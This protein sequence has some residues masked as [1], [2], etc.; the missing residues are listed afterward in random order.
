MNK[1]DNTPLK[2]YRLMTHTG[3]VIRYAILTKFEVNSKNYALGINGSN[4][5]YV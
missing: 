3:K 2:T 4:F 5:R 1:I